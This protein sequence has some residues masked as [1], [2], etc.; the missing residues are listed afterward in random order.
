M[1]NS[2]ASEF[3]EDAKRFVL[4]CCSIVDEAPLQLYSSA[5]IF[6]PER[7]VIRKT[8]LDDISWVTTKPVMEQNWSPCLQTLH[9]H[10]D[11]V[12]CVAFSPDSKLIATGSHDASI[13]I[14]NAVAGISEQTLNHNPAVM[15]VAFSPDSKLLASGSGKKAYSLLIDH[16]LDIDDD[17]VKIWDIATGSCLK[18]L[19]GH[20]LRIESVAFSPDSNLLASGSQEGVFR[21]W[22]VVTGT[23][24]Q[25]IR[26]ESFDEEFWHAGMAI[27]T[28]L[29]L[30]AFSSGLNGYDTF[31]IW[32]ATTGTFT[33]QRLPRVEGPETQTM[34]FSP[35]STLLALQD[36]DFVIH[37]LDLTSGAFRQ[38]LKGHM[39]DVRSI[40]ISSCSELLVSAT[41]FG[42][43][44]VWDIETG[45]CRQTLTATGGSRFKSVAFSP[46]SRLIVSGSGDQTAKIWDATR[47]DDQTPGN[48]DDRVDFVTFS[49]DS[50]IAVSVSFS[51]IKIWDAT[52]GSCQH[53]LRHKYGHSARISPNSKLL[54]SKY[55]KHDVKI[56]N[57]ATGSCQHTVLTRHWLSSQTQYF[58]TILEFSPDSRFLALVNYD[59]KIAIWDVAMGTYR[60]MLERPSTGSGPIV[61]SPNS[62]LLASGTSEVH[63]WDVTTGACQWAFD[64]GV[65]RMAMAFSP[66]SRLL[67]REYEDGALKIWD[68]A[69]G[70][71]QLTLGAGTVLHRKL[72][73]D[74]TGS[75]VLTGGPD[76]MPTEHRR[77]DR[78]GL[79]GRMRR[80]RLNFQ[81]R[82]AQGDNQVESYTQPE[83]MPLYGCGMSPD[84]TWFTWNGNNVIWLPPDYRP[85]QLHEAICFSPSDTAIIIGC[86][87]RVLIT[88]LSGLGRDSVWNPK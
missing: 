36:V 31:Q 52:T 64:G 16:F 38:K 10:S 34:A 66:D 32:D 72:S 87:S 78:M 67:A 62:R 71:C 45:A 1:K 26:F 57:L 63:V 11:E 79:T 40:A 35:D 14:W 51:N 74:A 29:K 13:N 44:K 55:H 23:C 68:V 15:S 18:T 70:V 25:A 84:R 3:L 9:S 33:S 85:N 77:L 49:L 27:S 22:N 56:W 54:A 58:E 80:I 65:G 12:N 76:R 4:N 17:T 2:K 30:I 19:K 53:R 59:S 81:N 5:L 46:D 86:S 83:D 37:I 28:N 75:Y 50:R 21:I 69:T 24:Q 48:L 73:F 20:N 82:D 39:S 47:M 88:D 6:A 7:S 41:E 42:T 8:F 61:F 60:Q 43:I